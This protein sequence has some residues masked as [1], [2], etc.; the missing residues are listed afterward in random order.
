MCHCA[1][2]IVRGDLPECRFRGFEGERMQQGYSALESLL[3][4]WSTGCWEVHRAKLLLVERV[5]VVS[6]VGK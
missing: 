4:L 6:F 1:T 3:D 5:V 2:G